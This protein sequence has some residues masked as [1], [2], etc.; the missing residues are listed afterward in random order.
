MAYWPHGFGML[1]WLV[2]L[3]GFA[4]VAYWFVGYADREPPQPV[5]AE[6][7]LRQSF[8]AGEIGE[9]EYYERLSIL[10]STE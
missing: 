1:F 9:V 2:G 4:T 3:A 5:D 7:L 10:R 6:H 8:A